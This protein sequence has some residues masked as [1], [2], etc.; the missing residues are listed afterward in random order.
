MPRVSLV[1]FG[2]NMPRKIVKTDEVVQEIS[3]QIM[4]QEEEIDSDDTKILSTGSTLLDLAIYGKRFRGGGIP[5]GILIEIYGPSSAGKTS[6]ACEIGGSCQINGGSVKF[7]DP[8]ARLDRQY[9]RIY[10]MRIAG[11]EDYSQPDTVDQLMENIYT[12]DPQE[13]ATHVVIG[14]SVAALSTDAELEGDDA[15]GMRRAKDFSKGLRRVCRL[16]NQKKWIVIFINQQRKGPNSTFTPGGNAI[17]YH[18]SLRLLVTF[19]RQGKSILKKVK[20][21]GKIIEKEVGIKSIVR[22]TKSSIDE[23][24]R[25]VPISIKFGYGIDSI[26]DELQYIKDNLGLTKYKAVTKEYQSLTKAIKWVEQ[27]GLE[28]ELREEV[29]CLWYEIENRFEEGRKR[30]KRW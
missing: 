9:S 23:P 15:Y 21:H 4:N 29:I 1:F 19:A 14:D 24:G 5:P 6:I 12:F 10:G 26:R 2:G 17:P 3:D 7:L 28:N 27:E 22:V 30:K 18:S 16:I 25:V 11:E 20:F 8:E 13:D